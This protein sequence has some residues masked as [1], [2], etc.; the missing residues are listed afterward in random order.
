[1]TVDWNSKINLISR[2]DVDNFESHHILHSLAITRYI[3]FLDGSSIFDLGT[4]GGLPGL[5]LAIYYP[6]VRFTLVDARA[7]KIMVVN[8]M[9][10]ALQLDNVEAHHVR[11]EE[12]K[13]KFDFVVTRAVAPMDKLMSWSSKL[14][15]DTDR[16]AIPNGII[17]LKGG[18]LADELKPVQ[19]QT[20]VEKVPIAD[21]FSE[22]FLLEKYIVYAQR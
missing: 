11:A 1:M 14:I 12:F 5:P 21:F 20:F 9:I 6:N 10:Q 22:E 15:S 16:H 17:A 2:K 3:K 7:K 4:G 8:E 18:N 13:G 19:K